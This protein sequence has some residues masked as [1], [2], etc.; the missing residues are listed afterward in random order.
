M[1][2]RLL[3]MKKLGLQ[4]PHLIKYLGTAPFG[5]HIKTKNSKGCMLIRKRP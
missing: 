4:V 1:Q 5:V 2:L 3:L